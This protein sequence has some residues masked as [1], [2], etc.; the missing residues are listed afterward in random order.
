MANEW[1]TRKMTSRERRDELR[2][3]AYRTL[4]RGSNTLQD[5]W[6]RADANRQTRTQ[7][8]VNSTANVTS[9][10]QRNVNTAR[11]M[12]AYANQPR[13]SGNGNSPI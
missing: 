11:A 2:R 8:R 4:V 10:Q 12:L 13:I 5:S 3:E 9:M 6:E 7:Q 1:R